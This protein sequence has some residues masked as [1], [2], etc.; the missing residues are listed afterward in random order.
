MIIRG[1]SSN[2]VA[3]RV[4]EKMN[5]SYKNAVRLVQTLPSNFPQ[6]LQVL[7]SK[8]ARNSYFPIFKSS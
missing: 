4:S 1:E 8:V 2:K 7:L 5:T 6:S 3:A